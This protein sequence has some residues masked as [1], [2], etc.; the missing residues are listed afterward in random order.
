MQMRRVPSSVEPLAGMKIVSI[1]AGGWHSAAVSSFGDVYL[2]GFNSHGQLGIRLYKDAIEDKDPQKNPAVYP[3]PQLVEVT[4]SCTRKNQISEEKP[5]DTETD[6]IS[7]ESTKSPDEITSNSDSIEKKDE[8]KAENNN[9]IETDVEMPLVRT[10]AENQSNKDE[11]SLQPKVNDKENNSCEEVV[12]D[13]LLQSN[14]NVVKVFCGARHTVIKMEC[15]KFFAAGSNESGQL[16][17]G[18]KQDIFDQFQEITSISDK[19]A[20]CGPW[21]TIFKDIK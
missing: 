20:V 3:I 12:D 4:C 16:G 19:D 5:V 11:T 2:W 13:M 15:G 10:G 21:S 7:S 9:Q 17:L 6:T 18:L 1:S 14:C 8:E